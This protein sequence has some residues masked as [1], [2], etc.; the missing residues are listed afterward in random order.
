[1]NINVEMTEQEFEA[2]KEWLRVREEAARAVY[3][4]GEIP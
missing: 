1:M 3:D 4:P 2:F